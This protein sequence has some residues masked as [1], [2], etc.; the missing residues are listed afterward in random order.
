LLIGVL[1]FA[2]AARADNPTDH[3]RIAHEIDTYKSEL[4]VISNARALIWDSLSSSDTA[5]ASEA[6]RYLDQRF[7]SGNVVAL[8]PL[9]R[10]LLSYW[11]A[12][13]ER[14]L[15]PSWWDQPFGS[16]KA[17]GDDFLRMWPYFTP[18]PS[19]DIVAPLG[20]RMRT[21]LLRKSSDSGANLYKRLQASPVS[22]EEKAFLELLFLHL[23]RD[24]RSEKFEEING[25]SEDFLK[26]Y[27]DSKLSIVVRRYIQMRYRASP[28]GWGF[29]IG[30]GALAPHGNLADVVKR[31]GAFDLGV[32]ISHK[33]V[34]TF[35]RG[36]L[37]FANGTKTAVDQNGIYNEG[38]KINLMTADAML[39]YAVLDNHRVRLAPFVGLSLVSVSEPRPEKDDAPDLK[40]HKTGLG[41][42]VNLDLMLVEKENAN[43]PIPSAVDA[44]IRVHLQRT[45]INSSNDAFDGG[46]N[47]IS[48][49][50]GATW[51]KVRRVI[52]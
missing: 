20:D 30:L 21:D 40:F 46:V 1:A 22:N 49:A 39:G 18:M 15:D 24:S 31:T 10:I 5:K 33:R 2:V 35:W 11:V 48:V 23:T 42:G 26:R 47:Q 52:E 12:D 13:F 25:L 17:R 32:D 28:W 50:L 51:R 9:E 4:Q 43:S 38:T 14:I 45:D 34:M 41:Y 37:G 8:L 27:P 7:S 19:E 6:I 3:R 29:E 36:A 16:V 44:F